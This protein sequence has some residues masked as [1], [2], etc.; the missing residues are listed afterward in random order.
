MKYE[1]I[2]GKPVPAEL[3][4]ELRAMGLGDD[5]HLNSALRTQDAVNWARKQGAQ[6]SSQD[7]LYDGFIHGRP[8]FNPANRPGTSTHELRSDGRA[9]PGPVGRPLRYWEVGIDST[10]TQELRR[11]AAKHGFTFTLTY[12]GSVG[13]AQHGNFRKEPKIITFKPLKKG[14]KGLRVRQMKGRLVYLGDLAGDVHKQDGGFGQKTEDALKLFQ[15]HW[16]LTPDGVY[17][18]HTHHQLLYAVKRKKKK[19][20]AAAAYVKAKKKAA[21]EDK[22]A[23]KSEIPIHISAKG[24]AFIAEFEGGRGSDGKFHPYWDDIGG[25]WTQ[26]FGHTEN[27]SKND[28]PW[29][30]KQAEDQLVYDMDHIYLPPVLKLKLNLVQTRLD[31]IGAA[32]YNLGP[33]ILDPGRSLGDALRKKQG[34]EAVRAALALY[35]KG[36]SP[37]KP[38]AG[39]IR[40][41]KAEGNLYVHGSYNTNP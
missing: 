3:A 23:P 31:A 21:A 9:Y 29:T 40:R 38:V 30:L 8:G 36:G 12:P 14:S 2:N 20:A 11:R 6:L 17:G 7:E 39:L 1:L 37:P 28:K 34:P 10:N 27:V 13:E 19:R 33:G 26:G 25:V 18:I 24:A 32:V 5:I 35:N 41:R 15:R 16:G 22:G 4:P